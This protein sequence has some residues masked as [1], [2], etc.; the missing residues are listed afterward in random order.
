MRSIRMKVALYEVCLSYIIYCLMFYFIPP[1]RQ[2]C[3]I[4]L[5]RGKEFS[6]YWEKGF[7]SEEGND[8]YE[9]CSS[10]FLIYG[11]IETCKN[12]ASSYL[13][14]GDESMSEIR[15]RTTVKGN[16]THLPYILRKPKPLG[17]YFKT[18]SCYVLEAMLFIEINRGK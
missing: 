14:V 10:K 17:I 6:K 9:W 12:I 4:S 8:T 7:N 2:I 18:S 11:F 1:P 3:G 15:F 13:K 16:L 5:V